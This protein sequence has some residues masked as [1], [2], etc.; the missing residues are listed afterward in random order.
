MQAR[1]VEPRVMRGL[2]FRD[3]VVERQWRRVDDAG[4]RRTMRQHASGHE[5]AR[6][7]TDRAARDEIAPA[8]RQKIGGAGAGADEMHGHS[9]L[10]GADRQRAGDVGRRDA[11]RQQAAS[12]PR[13]DERG[14]FRDAAD[15]K[16]R[17]HA[18]RVGRRGALAGFERVERQKD[19]IDAKR[20]RRLMH[21]RLVGLAFER[22]QRH[23]RKIDAHA[24][25]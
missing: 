18:R 6:V 25:A 8:Q 10:L 24:S 22:A 3:D 23:A 13:A 4:V 1:H 21:A 9:V 19:E 17:L 11:R 16:H 2:H 14:G 20:R 15:A 12:R 7:K 5:R